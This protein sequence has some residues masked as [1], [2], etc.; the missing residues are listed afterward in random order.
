[1]PFTLRMVFPPSTVFSI[2]TWG[3]HTTSAFFGSTVSV[4]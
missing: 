2:G 4:V 3:N 1:M